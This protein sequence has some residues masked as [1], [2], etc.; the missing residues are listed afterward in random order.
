MF[1][2]ASLLWLVGIQIAFSQ[3]WSLRIAYFTSPISFL[4]GCKEFSHINS[5][6]FTNRL[7]WTSLQVSRTLSLHSS[8]LFRSMTYK[9]QL[10]Q[11]LIYVSSTQQNHW[12]VLGFSFYELPSRK[13]RKL[14]SL[15]EWP[16]IA[17]LPSL[18]DYSPPILPVV[19][20]LKRVI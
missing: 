7:N 3:V 10:P 16:H 4:L 9:F 11:L 13:C 12:I 18:N 14:G 2:E 20:N 1:S 8:W 6:I 17:F 15:K 19:Q 5:F